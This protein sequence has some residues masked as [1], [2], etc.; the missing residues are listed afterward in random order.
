MTGHIIG[1]HKGLVALGIGQ[2]LQGTA[3]GVGGGVNTL[4]SALGTVLLLHQ[5]AEEAEGHGGLG[6]GAGLGDDINGEVHALQQLL[7]LMHGVGTEAVAHEID[8]GGVLFL[9]VVVGG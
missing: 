5:L 2:R 8:I 4:G 9:Q 3:L 6:G 1:H 7:Y